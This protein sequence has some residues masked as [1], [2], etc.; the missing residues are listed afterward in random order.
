MRVQ[1]VAM[2]LESGVVQQPCAMPHAVR[3]GEGVGKQSHEG[4]I[5][6]AQPGQNDPPSGRPTRDD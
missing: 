5:V 1:A 6:A 3:Q 2:D 4:T